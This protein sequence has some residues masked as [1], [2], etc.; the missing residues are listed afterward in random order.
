MLTD[1]ILVPKDKCPLDVLAEL[2]SKTRNAWIFL[3]KTAIEKLQKTADTIERGSF[4]V[5]E[6][7]ET[8]KYPA[9]IIWVENTKRDWSRVPQINASDI[10]FHYEPYSPEYIFFLQM[11]D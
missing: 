1:V 2:G 6:W 5:M 4:V 11:A 7:K 9:T 10:A 3:H 8:E